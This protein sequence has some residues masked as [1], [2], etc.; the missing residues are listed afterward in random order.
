MPAL[1]VFIV[2]TAALLVTFAWSLIFG[3]TLA[4]LRAYVPALFVPLV[5]ALISADNAIYNALRGWADLAIQPF[6]DLIGRVIAG[7]DAL[8]QNPLAFARNTY[9]A[10]ERLFF[11]EIPF[12]IHAAE[13]AAAALFAQAEQ[14]AQALYGALQQQLAGLAS[15][16]AGLASDLQNLYQ[17]VVNQALPLAHQAFDYALH[18][19]QALWLQVTALVGLEAERAIAAEQAIFHTAEAELQALAGAEAQAV[20]RFES[21]LGSVASNLGSEVDQARQALQAEIVN[22]DD[23]LKKRIAD[24]IAA[25]PNA[26]LQRL[27]PQAKRALADDVEAIVVVSL[28]KIRELS[29]DVDKLRADYGPAVQAEIDKLKARLG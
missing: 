12:A 14:A 18:L 24:A 13:L 8:V 6:T 28:A 17:L 9:A 5:D 3:R 25:Y 11:V 26:L 20:A 23:L 10:I 16:A 19:V 1:D 29:R 7:I 21:E 4:A 22:L 15:M 2:A 27:G